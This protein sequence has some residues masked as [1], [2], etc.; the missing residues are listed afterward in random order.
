MKLVIPGE[1][2]DL[3]TYINRERT[4]RY[5]GA[6]LKKKNTEIVMWE[7]KAQ[8]LKKISGQVYFT[9]TWYCKNKKKDP[10]NISFARKFIFDGLVLAGVLSDDGWDEIEGFQDFF[11]VDE[12]RPRIEVEIS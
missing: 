3:N 8:R 6:S 9:F 1:L 12:K 7:A 11:E 4:N 10:D 2:T 5:G